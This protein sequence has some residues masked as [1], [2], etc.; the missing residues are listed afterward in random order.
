VNHSATAVVAV[1]PSAPCPA[2]RITTNPAVSPTMEPTADR[3]HRAAANTSPMTTMT[4]RTPYRSSRR[5]TIG[6]ARAPVSVPAR[7]AVEIVERLTPS[8]AIM[9]S[10]NTD[11]AAV[12][13][14]AVIA[15]IS[16][17]QPTMCQP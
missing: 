17:D 14:G 15:T 13:P 1:N 12:C 5:P 9:G 6:M 3:A 7:Y 10:M 8:W 2:I 4:R 16:A 11:T